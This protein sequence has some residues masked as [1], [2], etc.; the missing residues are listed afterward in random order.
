MTLHEPAVAMRAAYGCNGISTRQH[1][2]PAGGQDAWH[3]HFHVFPRYHDDDL[4]GSKP[5]P[6]FATGE[7]RWPHVEKLRARL[8]CPS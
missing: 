8:S 2:E 6:R 3:Y 5:L 4:Y 7:Q 1:N